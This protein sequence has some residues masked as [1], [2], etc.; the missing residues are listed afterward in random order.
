MR[1]GIDSAGC[2]QSNAQWIATSAVSNRPRPEIEMSDDFEVLEIYSPAIHDTI[3]VKEM[4]EA[5][6]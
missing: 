6:D 5:A 3:S 2:T 1:T 4:P